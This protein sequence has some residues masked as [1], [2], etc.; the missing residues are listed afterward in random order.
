MCFLGLTGYF[1]TLI[2]DYARIAVPLTDMLR[3]L[4]L[5]S[6][7]VKGTNQKCQQ[8]LRDH[9]LAQFWEQCHTWAFLQL[10]QILVSE[11]ILKAP[12][13]DGTPFIVTSDGCKDSFGA[14]LSQ[15]FTM[16]LPSGDT[17]VRTHPVKMDITSR[18]TVQALF[19]G[20][21]S[22]QVCLWPFWWDNL[23]IP[24]R[25]WDRLYCSLQYVT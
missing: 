3:N 2:K 15:Y 25:G 6:T 21:C 19:T 9:N 4:D 8:F 1:W 5:P 13:F 24:S 18:G 12:K 23:G 11:P 14:V 20:I 22:T 7:D 16:Q 17:I 10:K